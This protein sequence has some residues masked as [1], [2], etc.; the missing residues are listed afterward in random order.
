[1]SQEPFITFLFS[2][3]IS[4]YAS[5]IGKLYHFAQVLCGLAVTD[6][7]N[8][9]AASA[10]STSTANS[11]QQQFEA[12]VD[13]LSRIRARLATRTVL[14]KRLAGLGKS[15]SVP[16]VVLGHLLFPTVVSFRKPQDTKYVA[17][18]ATAL[19]ASEDR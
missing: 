5:I 18:V 16:L 6:N 19:R 7:A 13:V 15:A 1:M 14:S 8:A 17:L 10:A 11:S 9:V 2:L 12:F 3:K 4:T